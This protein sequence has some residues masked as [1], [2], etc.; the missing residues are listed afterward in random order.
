MCPSPAKSIPAFAAATLVAIGAGVLTGWITGFEPLMT[1]LPGLIRMKPNTAAAFLFAAVA[2]YFANSGKLGSVQAVCA[3]VV[4]AAGAVT[5]AEYVWSINVHVDQ[6]L[7]RDPVQLRFPGRMAHI[8]AANFLV[9]GIMLYP[10]RFRI[11]EKVTGR[12]G[13]ARLLWRYLR[14]CWLSLWRPSAVRLGP[15]HS[16][17]NPYRLRFSRSIS[18]LSIHSEKGW[19]CKDLP[20]GDSRRNRGAATGAPSYSDSDRSGSSFQPF[21]FRPTQTGHRLHCGV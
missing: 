20:G 5:L 19:F 13:A 14:H 8:S 3:L 1:V 12:S 17:G 9:T 10:F 7:F 11:R 16:H 15:L 2:L 21:Q 4:A 18:G 6:F